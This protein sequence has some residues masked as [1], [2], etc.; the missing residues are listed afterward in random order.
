MGFRIS[1]TSILVSQPQDFICAATHS[2]FALSCGEPTLFGSAASSFIQPPISAGSILASNAASRSLP[3]GGGAA[4]AVL[5]VP[6]AQA[7]RRAA[8]RT[9]N[10]MVGS[11]GRGGTLAASRPRRQGL[12]SL[13]R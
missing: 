3:V 11:P 12:V 6:R 13:L 7:E 4:H 5:T 9:L 8:T 1:K 2:A 10:F